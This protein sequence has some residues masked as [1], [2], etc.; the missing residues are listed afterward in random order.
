M[1]DWKKFLTE[2]RM[3]HRESKRNDPAYWSDTSEKC[4]VTS[5]HYKATAAGVEMLS[6]GG[7]AVDAA[8]AIS[9]ALGVVE[10][11]GSGLG[12]NGMVMMHLKEPSRTLAIEGPCR[13]PINA[14]PDEVSKAPRKYGYKAVAVPTNPAILEYLLSKYGTLRT[15]EVLSPAIE[16][17]EKGHTVTSFNYNQTLEY[18]KRLSEG[19]AGQFFLGPDKK[20][21]PPGTIYRQP[22]LAKTLLKMAESGFLDFYTGSIANSIVKDM[23]KY[24]GFICI[25]DL[26][27]IPWPEKKEP[28][29][30]NF[31]DLTVYSVP[32]PGGGTTLLQMLK[33]FEGLEPDDFKPD[34]PDAAVLFATIINQARIDRI[35]FKLGKAYENGKELPDRL[36]D[37][38]TEM[39][40][41]EL[42]EELTDQGET[43]HICVMDSDGNVVSMTQSIERSFG[44]KVAT[45]D[46]GFLYNGYMKAFKIQN[47]KHPHY[48]RPKAMARS[49]ASPT[50][51]L[52]RDSPRIAVGNTGSE[53]SNSGIFQVLVRLKSGQTP[54]EA[55][56]A[57]R[58]HCT[59]EREVLL[60]ANRF[61]EEAQSALKNHGFKLQP[62][63]DW[64][65][66]VGGLHLATYDGKIYTGVAEPRR[67]GAAAG[68]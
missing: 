66:K 53:R 48:L 11:A 39:L 19:T 67:D 36:S 16:L 34:S 62:L 58:L 30:C 28:V 51:A 4:I 14:T 68:L 3:L 20:P 49:N 5:A 38:R 29:S 31:G 40:V 15:S 24:G 22:V 56:K 50:I 25:E 63:D 37:E 12:G 41:K 60:E 27:D 32:P 54:F 42:R 10:P 13:A 64:S 21:H 46:L 6:K 52:Y 23:E 57:P 26:M 35:K 55:V 61:S 18:V 9:L 43:S 33:L 2:E 59:P 1:R 17:A 65:F 47:K 7:N 45:A 8:V 44:A